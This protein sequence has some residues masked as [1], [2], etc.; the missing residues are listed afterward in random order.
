LYPDL[1]FPT[2]QSK[3]FW[4]AKVKIG[5]AQARL[6][7][8][9]SE[10]SRR[11]LSEHLRIADSRLRVVQEASSPAFRRLESPNGRGLLQCL[12]VPLG[13]R[14]LVYVGG[15]SPHKNIGVLVDFMREIHREP[16]FSDVRLILVGDYETDVFFSCY[17][18]LV[19][20]VWRS[21][22]EQHVV[23]SGFLPD[24]QVA[25][26]LNSAVALV[27]PSFCEG[28]GL[29][30]LEAAACGAPV[31]ATRCSPLRELL[32]DG[33][34]TIDPNDRS[35]WRDAILAI[36]TRPELREHMRSAGLAASARLSWQSSAR[37]LLSVF[38]EVAGERAASA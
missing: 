16:G 33:A 22:L 32:G 13:A 14:Y 9:V 37:Q 35:G 21:G 19:Q 26:L 12:R 24:E 6:I 30:A 36:L 31:V 10:Y 18:E 1:V 27:L 8:T 20:Q 3:L 23:F 25:E 38:R 4:R 29:P 5:C 34:I 7:L 15:F 11:C 2:L 28:V 17:R